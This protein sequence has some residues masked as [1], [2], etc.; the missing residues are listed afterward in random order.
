MLLLFAFV[1]Y[2]FGLFYFRLFYLSLA[3]GLAHYCLLRGDIGL[4]TPYVLSLWFSPPSDGNVVGTSGVV[5]N[6]FI[7][8]FLVYLDLRLMLAFGEDWAG[9]FRVRAGVGSAFLLLEDG[10][11]Y[12]G[13]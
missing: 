13:F 4:E 7:S 9:L 12:K 10:L 6:F 2:F 5:E 11:S 8:Y 1:C 3:L